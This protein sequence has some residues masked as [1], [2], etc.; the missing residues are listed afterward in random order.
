MFS[1]QPTLVNTNV[2]GRGRVIPTWTGDLLH[3][4]FL[5]VAHTIRYYGYDISAAPWLQDTTSTAEFV[6]RVGWMVEALVIDP[7]DSN[8]W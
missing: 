6:S 5:E 3:L 4:K 8:H 2:L 1:H 7:F